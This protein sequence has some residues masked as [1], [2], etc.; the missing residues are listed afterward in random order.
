M[1]Q[2]KNACVISKTNQI[3][4]CNKFVEICKKNNSKKYVR[5][6]TTKYYLKK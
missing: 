5:A 4:N 3:T 1:K 6:K 2:K